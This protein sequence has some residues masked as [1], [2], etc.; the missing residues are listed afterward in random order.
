MELWG[1]IK[2]FHKIKLYLSELFRIKEINMNYRRTMKYAAAFLIILSLYAYAD[3]ISAM[4]LENVVP[5]ADVIIEAEIVDTRTSKEM[6]KKD[7]EVISVRTTTDVKLKVLSIMYGELHK[8]ELELKYSETAVKGVYA[9][10][11]GSGFEREFKKG[12]SCIALLP[13][14][15]ELLRLE[16]SENKDVILK[17]LKKKDDREN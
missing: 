16:K 17:L 15:Y 11:P 8:K 1:T 7:G 6:T 14:P 3:G 12:D 13:N 2:I 4:R 5:L 9:L 10:F